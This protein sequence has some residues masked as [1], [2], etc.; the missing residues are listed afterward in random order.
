MPERDDGAPRRDLDPAAVAL[1]LRR[2]GAATQPPWLHREV[3]RRMAQRLEIILARPTQ[4]LDWWGWSGAG[5]E[6]LQ[7]VYPKAQRVVVEPTAALAARSATDARPPWWS[8]RRWAGGDAGV[9]LD[10]TP[11]LPKVQLVWA[12]MT[13][14]SVPDPAALFARWREA[15]DVDGFVMFSALGPG[16]LRQLRALYQRLQWG[17]PA[18]GFVDMHDLGDMLVHAGFADPVMDQE[19]LRLQWQEPAAL[20]AELRALGGNS[21]PGRAAGLR[22][23]RWRDRLLAE[24]EGLRGV[25]GQITLDFEVAYGHAFK[26]APRARPGQPATVSVESLRAT[27]PTRRARS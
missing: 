20:L 7:G 3:A 13:L 1:W 11:D 9:L 21:S 16:S 15:L 4:L 26:A 5:R 2:L 19:T 8:T 22:T 10:S 18:Q 23:P 24:L 17:P 12:N 27:A 14:H 6:L 25:D